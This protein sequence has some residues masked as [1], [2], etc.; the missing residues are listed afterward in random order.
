MSVTVEDDN[1]VPDILKEISKL[2]NKRI[3]IGIFGDDDSTM[4]MIARVHEFGV[5]IEVTPK[6]RAYLHYIGIHLKEDTD[7]IHI[8]E[9]SFVR[10]AFDEKGKDMQQMGQ[11]GIEAVL[12]GKEKADIFLE[13]YG[14]YLRDLVRK[15]L[16]DLKEPP[17]HPVTAKRKGSS[18][19]LVDDGHLKRSITYRVV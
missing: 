17:N 19:P 7:E 1:N 4:L 2:Q 15:K 3:E 10:S 6:M 13:R 11:K 16:R 9:R 18:N 14:L 5:D 8:P 12:L